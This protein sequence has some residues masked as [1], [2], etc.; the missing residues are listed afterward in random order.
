MDSVL[1]Y[2]LSNAHG[3]LWLRPFMLGSYGRHFPGPIFGNAY[4]FVGSPR[5]CS[6]EDLGSFPMPMR[7]VVGAVR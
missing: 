4:P 7:E 5:V 6:T 1:E 2:M 3:L